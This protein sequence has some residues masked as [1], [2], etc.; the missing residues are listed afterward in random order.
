MT[1]TTTPTPIDSDD[2]MATLEP[3]NVLLFKEWFVSHGGSFHPGVRYSKSSSGRCNHWQLAP[4]LGSDRNRT[5]RYSPHSLVS[6]RYRIFDRCKWRGHSRT[7]CDYRDLPLLNH[8]HPASGQ[9]CSAAYTQTPRVVNYDGALDR[10]TI[11]HSLYLLSLD[12]RKP[13]DV[14]FLLS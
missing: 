1:S 13:R 6:S 14:N 12:D 3:H 5:D 2:S 8:H 10:T 11:D 7:R 9:G 4:A